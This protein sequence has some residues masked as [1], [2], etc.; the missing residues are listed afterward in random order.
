MHFADYLLM[1]VEKHLYVSLL[2]FATHF[3][4]KNLIIGLLYTEIAKTGRATQS[5][6]NVWFA[7]VCAVS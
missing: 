2:V 1:A 7:I 5:K 3:T 4:N 6:G